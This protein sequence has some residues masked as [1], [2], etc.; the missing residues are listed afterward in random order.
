ML[1]AVYELTVYQMLAGIQV[2][3][4]LK[5]RDVD[6]FG[7]APELAQDF[8]TNIIPTWK[9]ILSNHIS[10]QSVVARS[11]MPNTGEMATVSLTGTGAAGVGCYPVV[12]AGVITWR[13]ALAGR[14]YRGR[15]YLAGLVY[16]D[17]ADAIFSAGNQNNMATLANA[18][19]T[20]YVTNA[21][22]NKWQLGVWS[23]KNA[24]LAGQ[25][26]VPDPFQ[27][28]TQFTVQPYIATMGSRRSGRGH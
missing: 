27:P 23:R 18:I 24:A 28:V 7:H 19:K 13:S 1:N 12:C 25:P 20:R 22:A 8:A 11:L 14:R 5:L 10:F 3:N 4:T 26:G 21:A 2:V 15:M 6:G 17:G 9:N 16:T